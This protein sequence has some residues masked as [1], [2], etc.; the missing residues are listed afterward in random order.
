MRGFPKDHWLERRPLRHGQQPRRREDVLLQV[1]RT[2]RPRLQRR[3]RRR[4]ELVIERA[5]RRLQRAER[6][7]GA[8]ENGG[9]N[10]GKGLFHHGVI[11]T[12]RG[13]VLR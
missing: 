9:G 11:L 5:I 7:P 1:G 2:R 4:R 6:A 13:A 10:R 3:D 12:A 8:D